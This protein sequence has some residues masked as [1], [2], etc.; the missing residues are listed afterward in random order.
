MSEKPS[1]FEMIAKTMAGL[2]HVLAAEL[3]QLGAQNIKPL[4]RSVSFYGDKGFMYKA[5][6][7]LRTAISILKPIAFFK[8]RNEKEL[9]KHI[10]NMD[11]KTIFDVDQTFSVKAVVNSSQFT[12]SQYAAL[13]VKDAIVDRFRDDLNKRP[14]VELDDPDIKINIH[15]NKEKVNVS[16]DSS[17]APLFKRGYKSDVGEAPMN[18]V[19]AAGL[20]LLSEWNGKGNFVDP[21]CGSGTILIEAAMIAMN[22]PAQF[23]RQNF[24]FMHWAD[25]DDAL[26]EL[27]KTSSMNKVK[28]SYANIIGYDNHPGM[29]KMAQ[30]NVV[31]ADMEEFIKVKRMDF[32]KSEKPE[33]PTHI[34]FNPPYGE[35]LAIG[36]DNF[37][38]KIGD[39]LKQHYPNTTAWF[40]TSDIDGIKKVGLRP[41]KKIPVK[42]GSL[43]CK[44]VRFDLYEGS[45][46]TAKN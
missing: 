40:I 14:N 20:I 31:N 15:I 7:C 6:L 39:T 4:V 41:S 10:Y 29:C 24:G 22:I 44:L 25:F 19:L 27:I 16:L 30:A 33:G 46:K 5:N 37:Y 2:E 3:L 23:K 38:K 1:N 11:W 32:F 8:V 17:G 13:K 36:M 18:E 35:R 45:K 21:M 26:F 9:Y 34:L 42:N 43:D 28:E 12:H